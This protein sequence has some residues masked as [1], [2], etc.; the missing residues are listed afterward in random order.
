MAGVKVTDKE[1]AALIRCANMGLTQGQAAELTLLSP[2]AVSRAAAK[3][4]IRFHTYRENED[5]RNARASKVSAKAKATSEPNDRRQQEKDQ[6]KPNNAIRRNP[7]SSYNDRK[8]ARKERAIE[9]IALAKTPAEKK[10]IA[11]AWNVMEFEIEMAMLKKRPPLPVPEKK[12][13]SAVVA[14]QLAKMKQINA[15]ERVREMIINC[16]IPGENLTARE[17]SRRLKRQDVE[18]TPQSVN[19]FVNGMAQVGK[20]GRY[21]G[22]S[23]RY[24]RTYW[25]YF[26]PEG[27]CDDR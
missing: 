9:Q 13:E 8:N 19:G 12:R 7:S 18:L 21:K 27:H 5:G 2:T 14:I 22:P 15:A 23:D 26:L 11:Y 17:I 6:A 16:F 25:N 3:Y 4:G 10:E 1:V 24:D 20:L